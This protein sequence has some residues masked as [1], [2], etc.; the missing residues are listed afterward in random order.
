MDVRFYPSAPTAVGSLP[1]AD[2]TC[3]GPLDYY[4]CNKVRGKEE[5]GGGSTREGGTA[6]LGAS[7]N[8][9][10]V[11]GGNDP[12]REG[13]GRKERKCWRCP[14]VLSCGREF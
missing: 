7:R 13:E 4:H 12:G 2:P 1:G 14:R 10:A 6:S 11:E 5:D 3:L 9:S 8:F